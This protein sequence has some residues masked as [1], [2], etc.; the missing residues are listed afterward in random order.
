MDQRL[1]TEANLKI[2][3][4]A[5]G[6]G[7]SVDA[8]RFYERMGLVEPEERTASGYRLYGS[9]AVQRVAD[10]KTLQ[11]VGLTLEEIAA[12]FASAGDKKV[13]CAHVSPRF[14]AVIERLNTK[15]AELSALRDS[16]VA[17]S[18]QCRHTSCK[19]P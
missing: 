10:L 16:A 13:A 6:A 7:V 14:E 12:V 1:D 5:H 9:H 19:C 3:E 11:A 18:E 8:I 4:V 15:I 17:Q 2:G